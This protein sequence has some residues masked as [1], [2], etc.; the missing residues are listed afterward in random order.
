MDKTVEVIVAG[1]LCLDLLPQMNHIRLSDLAIPGHL[2]ETGP[3]NFSTG[4]AVSNTG[5]ALHRLGVNV[6]LMST[7]GDDLIGQM[8][9]AFL[10]GRDQGLARNVVKRPGIPSSYTVVLSPEKAD[11]IFLHC[12][13]TNAVFTS[14]DIDYERVGQSKIFHLGY[15]PLLPTLIENN[16]AELARLF[17]Q[18]KASGAIT[19]LDMTLPDASTPSGSANWRAIL[20][21]TLPYVDIFIPSIE[22]A[23]FMLRRADYDRWHG[24][25]LLNLSMKYLDSLANEIL[26]MGSTAVT[27]FKLGQLG[28]F[29]RTGG[30]ERFQKFGSL[31]IK[32]IEWVN[33]H[34]WHPAFVV[35]V[36]GT[37]G[38]GDSAYAGFLSAILKGFSAQDSARWACAVGA[39]NVEAA[40]AT[41]GVQDWDTTQKRIKGVWQ[42]YTS[43]LPSI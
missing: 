25:V 20:E 8:I 21:K 7:V 16:G 15:P 39:C 37:T 24:E 29:L 5:L 34:I 43:P 32:P 35:N 12:T 40:D 27:G 36:I 41:S 14:A 2:F 4:G 31:P 19:S 38:A 28:I 11:R 42:N 30:E 13:G 22:E 3:M 26:Q 33:Q 18:A 1:H 17:Q 23:L 6:S 10:E 9:V